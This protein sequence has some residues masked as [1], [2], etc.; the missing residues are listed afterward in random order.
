MSSAHYA[1]TVLYRDLGLFSEPIDQR[2]RKSQLEEI[3]KLAENLK[4][5]I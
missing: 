1:K 2:K 3:D 5:Q 4:L